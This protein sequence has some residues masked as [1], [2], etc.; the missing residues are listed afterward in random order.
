VTVSTLQIT[1]YPNNLFRA[2]I[3]SLRSLPLRK[4]N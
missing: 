2:L 1:Q 4:I 3:C